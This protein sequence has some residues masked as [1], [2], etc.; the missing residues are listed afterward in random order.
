MLNGKQQ[1]YLFFVVKE[2][3]GCDLKT[4]LFEVRHPRE[5]KDVSFLRDLKDRDLF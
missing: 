1:F 4:W 2:N 3:S 5:G